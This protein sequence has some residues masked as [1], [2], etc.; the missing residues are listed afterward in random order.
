[1]KSG[2]VLFCI[3]RKKTK[4][5]SFAYAIWGVCL[6]SGAPESPPVSKELG[7]VNGGWGRRSHF[8]QW[9]SHNPNETQWATH[10]QEGPKGSWGLVRRRGSGRETREIMIEIHY[11]HV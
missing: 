1:M 7:A 8:L 3:T 5:G 11:A 10:T 4:V 2:I 9:C 6:N